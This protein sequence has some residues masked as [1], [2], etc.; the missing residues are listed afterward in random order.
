M[1]K[2][3]YESLHKQYIAAKH[4]YER[5][6]G[7]I[8][9]INKIK[10]DKEYANQILESRMKG[11]NY[12]IKQKIPE[13]IREMKICTI[14]WRFK[15][16]EEA[17]NFYVK[18]STPNEVSEYNEIV[19]FTNSNEYCDERIR[20]IEKKKKE[21]LDRMQQIVDQANLLLKEK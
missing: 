11:I 2:N 5:C 15:L 10:I 9:F 7:T 3:D 6:V 21:W 17:Y 4:D 13:I 14:S 12:T 16:L 20:Q 1:E 18:E 8:V 19:K